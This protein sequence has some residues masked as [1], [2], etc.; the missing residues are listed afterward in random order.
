MQG[1]KHSVDE[2]RELDLL[3]GSCSRVVDDGRWAVNCF[4]LEEQ[5]HGWPVKSFSRG[6]PFD[7]LDKGL[8]L[9]LL[10]KKKTHVSHSARGVF[11]S[12]LN[13]NL[14]GW[15]RKLVSSNR[16]LGR[17]IQKLLGRIARFDLGPKCRGFRLGRLLSNPILR[18]KLRVHFQSVA[19]KDAGSVSTANLG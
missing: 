3:P 6:T 11:S 19:S 16:A 10:G 18:P 7:P 13:L 12:R 8:I 4:D 2:L 15:I 14:F 5:P 17:V 9:R 1:C